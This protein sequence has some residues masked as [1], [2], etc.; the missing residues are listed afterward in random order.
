LPGD[1]QAAQLQQAQQQRLQ[2]LQDS[3]SLL[4]QQR[5]AD[6]QH[7]INQR[8]EALR[9]VLEQARL[10][11]PAIMAVLRRSHVRQFNPDIIGPRVK[12]LQEAFGAD[13]VNAML[14]VEPELLDRSAERMIDHFKGLS[15]LL[16]AGDAFAKEIVVR[17][18]DLLGHRPELMQARMQRMGVLLQV[19]CFV[20]C[21]VLCGSWMLETCVRDTAAAVEGGSCCR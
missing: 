15:K 12:Q 10:S 19:R 1:Q 7:L 13:T 21:V 11:F 8:Q 9:S 14:S 16:G 6:R 17:C 18:P 20:L 2:E 5:Q 4:L 3:Q